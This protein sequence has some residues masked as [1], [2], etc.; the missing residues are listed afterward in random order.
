M[1]HFLVNEKL[2]ELAKNAILSYREDTDCI[3]VNV[4][5]GGE[6]G[7]PAGSKMLQENSDI[8]IKNEKNS[9]FAITC[10]NGFRKVMEIEPDDCYIICSNNDILVHR[11]AIEELKRPFET[12]DNVAITGIISTKE[13]TWEGQELKYATPWQKITEGGLIQDRMQDGGL[14][15]SKKSIL[16]KVGL[17][18]ELFIR[19]GYEDVDLFLRMR[20]SFGMKIVMSGLS[21][22]WHQQGATR[23]LSEAVGAVNDFGHESKQIENKNLEYFIQKWGFNPHTRQIWFDKELWNS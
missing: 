1:P 8:Y 14:W 22:Y 7:L 2:I 3:L 13:L 21:A 17:F 18:D 5:D 4:D 9:G 15:M 20:D 11:K 6:Y 16:E 12:F 10:N 23:W 19:G